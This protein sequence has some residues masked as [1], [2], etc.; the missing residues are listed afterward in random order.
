MPAS[1]LRVAL[2]SVA[3]VH[4]FGWCSLP[5]FT[6]FREDD[7]PLT[8]QLVFLLDVRPG[9][10]GESCCRAVG[11]GCPSPRCFLGSLGSEAAGLASLSLCEAEQPQSLV[12]CCLHPSCPAWWAWVAEV[13]APEDPNPSPFDCMLTNTG[14]GS[15]LPENL[16]VFFFSLFQ[17]E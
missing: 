3:C 14:A 12:R 9:A 2:G 11:R 1:C 10:C 13:K 15:A 6:A 17:S 8:L 16:W 7:S 5:F 4:S